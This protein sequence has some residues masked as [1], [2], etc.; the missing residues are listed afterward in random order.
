MNPVTDYPTAADGELIRR[1]LAV[2]AEIAGLRYATDTERWIIAVNADGQACHVENA[3]RWAPVPG[4]LL[5]EML[6]VPFCQMAASR[7]ARQEKAAERFADVPDAAV[8]AAGAR[9][10]RHME[11]MHRYADAAKELGL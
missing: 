5:A 8:M 2:F 7:E 11:R 1:A 9:Y 10:V 6:I 3:E 4:E